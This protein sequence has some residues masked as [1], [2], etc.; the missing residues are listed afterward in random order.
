MIY[1]E[2]NTND[3]IYFA[4]SGPIGFLH[5]RFKNYVYYQLPVG[6]H[7]GLE[8]LLYNYSKLTDEGEGFNYK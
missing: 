5:T 4:R 2:L 7:A 8:D 6:Y 1:D 3:G